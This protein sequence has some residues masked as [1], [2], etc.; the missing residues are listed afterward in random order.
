MRIFHIPSSKSISNRLLIIKY[1][2]QNEELPIDNLSQAE[3]TS[4]MKDFIENIKYKITN[5]FY[6]DNAGTVSRFIIGLCSII[7]REFIIDGSQRLR[8]RP[9]KPLIDILEK[10]GVEINFLENNYSLPIR[11]HGKKD[12]ESGDIEIDTS[13]SSQFL[14]SLLLVSPKFKTPTSFILRGKK[15]SYPYIEMTIRLMQEFGIDLSLEGGIIKVNSGEYKYHRTEVEADWSSASFGYE[16]AYITNK[17]VFIPSLKPSKLQGDS[18]AEEYFKE[19]SLETIYNKDGV[20][21]RPKLELEKPR[22]IILDIGDSPDLFL[23][24]VI[25][26]GLSQNRLILRNTST[27]KLKESNRI[28]SA[29]INL[30]KVGIEFIENEDEV[31]IGNNSGINKNIIIETFEDHR[32]A[33]AFGLLKLIE[34]SVEIDNPECVNKSFPNFWQNL[35]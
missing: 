33:M 11:I 18:I 24:L 32:V 31:I 13:L 4:I 1:L 3:D 23:P 27:L 25:V 17:D 29:K 14:T 21:I 2:S 7:D 22:D 20:I 6:S 30:N 12:I 34:S 10:L 19:F 35:E 8:E 15:M 16:L 5:K 9:I 28:E 26:G